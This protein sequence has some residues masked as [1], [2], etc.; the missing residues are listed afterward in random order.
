MWEVSSKGLSRRFGSFG[1]E[2]AC[3]RAKRALRVVGHA[4]GGSLAGV[5][6]DKH[7]SSIASRRLT[8]LCRSCWR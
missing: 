5:E 6:I 2:T 8:A 4:A 3:E 1:V 7:H